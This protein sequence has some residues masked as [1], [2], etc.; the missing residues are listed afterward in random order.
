MVVAWTFLSAAPIN[1]EHV[2]H[3]R[4][5]EIYDWWVNSNGSESAHLA[6]LKEGSNIKVVLHLHVFLL[7]N[8]HFTPIASGRVEDFSDVSQPGRIIMIIGW[9]NPFFFFLHV[10]FQHTIIWCSGGVL[11]TFSSL[12]KHQENEK[13]WLHDTHSVC[14]WARRTIIVIKY[15]IVL[16]YASMGCT[17]EK[18]FISLFCFFF[19][20]TF[21]CF[22]HLHKVRDE[23]T[24]AHRNFFRQKIEEEIK[25]IHE[26]RG[27]LFFFQY[28]FSSSLPF[29]SLFP[30]ESLYKYIVKNTCDCVHLSLDIW[31]PEV[32]LIRFNCAV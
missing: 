15:V 17:L 23:N 30:T 32:N 2:Q 8:V 19:F 13:W 12:R 4:R 5:H 31:G 29:L 3:C 28:Y 18:T 22:K 27:F 7:V 1:A 6:C 21:W 11:R 24:W 9:K 25:M 14:G 16:V 26:G 20:Y 10:N